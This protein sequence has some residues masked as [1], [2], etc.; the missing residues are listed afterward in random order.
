VT[1]LQT[2]GFGYSGLAGT[3]R[4]APAEIGFITTSTTGN[5]QGDIV[6][7]NRSTTT[8]VAPVEV[9]RVTSSGSVGIG[10][11]TPTSLLDVDG[12]IRALGGSLFN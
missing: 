2:I 4:Y 6:F 5:T 1:A 9:L 8:N 10:T 7:A 12:G 11:P 3:T